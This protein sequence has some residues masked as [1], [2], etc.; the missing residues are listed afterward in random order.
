MPEQDATREQV[1]QSSCAYSSVMPFFV[2]PANHEDFDPGELARMK[3]EQGATIS[4]CIPARDE[5]ATIA[6]IV[7][8]IRSELVD[9]AGLVDEVVVLDDG[10]T[11]RTAA[12]AA[13][14]GARVESVVAILPEVGPGSG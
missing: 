13:A 5:A 4:V 7:G 10:S 11:D 12:L 1:A 9:R 6:A 3:A 14:A 2:A 8:A